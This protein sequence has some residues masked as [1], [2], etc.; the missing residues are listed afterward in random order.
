MWRDNLTLRITSYCFID[1]A[2]RAGLQ[3]LKITLRNPQ[4]PFMLKKIKVLLLGVEKNKILGIISDLERPINEVMSYERDTFETIN[5][6]S[7][8]CKILFWSCTI[9]KVY[10]ITRSSKVNVWVLILKGF[11]VHSTFND[12]A[13]YRADSLLGHSKKAFKSNLKWVIKKLSDDTWAFVSLRM[14]NVSQGAI[15]VQIRF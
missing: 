4:H 12:R 5:V 9:K 11:H 2:R 3:N 15:I 8:I 14:T 6:A 10:N 1:A 7:V 13:D